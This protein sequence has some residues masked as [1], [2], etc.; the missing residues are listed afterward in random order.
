MPI[1]Y[2]IDSV[3]QLVTVRASDKA[4]YG[5]VL[6]YY[7]DLRA[8]PDFSPQFSE[9]VDLREVTGTRLTAAE[10]SSLA[11][12]P[13][14]ETTA[15]RALVTGSDLIFG[16]CRMFVAYS[17]ANADHNI[18]IFHGMDEGWRWLDLDVRPETD[19]IR[20]AS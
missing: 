11:S 6:A 20:I 19:S 10:I 12:M 8:D 5:D 4:T 13:V 1:T 16:L 15:R 2:H 17:V 14:F 18:G 7:R 3:R 9:L